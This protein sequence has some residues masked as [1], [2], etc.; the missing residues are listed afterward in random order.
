MPE[1]TLTAAPPAEAW[2]SAPPA[3]AQ[4]PSAPEEPLHSASA[5]VLIHRVGQLRYAFRAEGRAFARTLQDRTNRLL[6]PHATVLLYE[7]LFGTRDLL[8]WLVHLRTP[9]D[10][11]LFLHA[12]DRDPGVRQV[13]EADRLA[14]KGG[15][16][17]ERMFEEGTFQEEVIVPQHGAAP[18]EEAHDGRFVPPARGQTSVP[19]DEQ[20]NSASAGAIVHRTGQLR[21]AHR[22]E[23]RDFACAWLERVNVALRGRA[24]AFLYEETWGRQDR[25]HWLIHLRS[26]AD[27]PLLAELGARDAGYRDLFAREWVPAARGG[28]T[29][30]RMFVEATLRDAVLVPLGAAAADGWW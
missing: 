15:G 17:W 8:H 11:A 20:L 23:G 6:H 21:Y 25:I 27:L 22:H 29:W 9:N 24:T 26:P 2:K 18:G 12:A 16:N 28:G 13:V 14:E 30:A 4:T 3:H 1:Q 19:P 5:G 10:Y 7:E